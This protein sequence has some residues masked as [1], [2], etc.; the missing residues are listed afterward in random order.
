MLEC[1]IYHSRS[2]ELGSESQ[3]SLLSGIK[4]TKKVQQVI[5]NSI[6]ASMLSAPNMLFLLMKVN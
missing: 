6:S 4:G 5:Q 3:E 1:G 2:K